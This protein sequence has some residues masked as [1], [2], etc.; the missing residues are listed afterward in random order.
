MKPRSHSP[1]DLGNAPSLS[2]KPRKRR[3]RR[4]TRKGDRRSGREPAL[5]VHKR[6]VICPPDRAGRH[7]LFRLGGL[8]CR[9]LVI[10]L[11]A[12]GFVTFLSDALQFGVPGSVIFLSTLVTVIL[13]M[14]FCLH[15]IGKVISPLLAGGGVT[16][17]VLLRPDLPTNLLYGV[18]SLYNAALDRLYRIGYLTYVQYKASIPASA[19]EEELRLLGVALLSVLVALLFTACFAKRVRLIPPAIL[20]TTILVVTLTFNIYSNRIESNLG[21]ALIIIS[22]ASVLVMATYDRL[23]NGRDNGLYD[24][25]LQLFSE[26]DRPMMPAEYAEHVA[27][28]KARRAARRALRR[29]QRERVVTVDEELTDYFRAGKKV[30]SPSKKSRADR[31]SKRVERNEARALHRRVRAA[32]AYDRATGQ[33]KTAM[34]GYAAA[35]VLVICLIAVA[36]PAAAIK[37]NF[38]TIA[39][40]DEK[41][42]LA[43]SYVT[44]LLRGDNDALDRLEY[45]ADKDNFKPRDTKLEQPEFQNKQVLYVQ[46][47]YNANYYLRGW[48]GTDYKD[49][50]WQAVDEATLEEYQALFGEDA[51]PAEDMR[52]GFYHYMMPTLVRRPD[53]MPDLLDRYQANLDYGFVGV[54]V[55]MRRVN[56]PSSMTYFPASYDR[57]YGVF[58]FQT[59]T[60]SALT[61]V[62]YYDGLYTGR[63][64]DENALSY[65]TMAYAPVM[66]RPT[67]IQNQARLQA[68][69]NLQKEALLPY[70]AMTVKE[71][72]TVI[73]Q[74]ELEVF[75]IGD[76][77]AFCYTIKKR[78]EEDIT[79]TMYHNLED[80]FHDTTS[81][82]ATGRRHRYIINTEVGSLTILMDG[83][84]VIGTQAGDPTEGINLWA[85]YQQNLSDD[86]R[87]ELLDYLVTE[88][89]YSDFV[90]RTYLGKAESTYL[91][92]LATTI[93]EQAHTEE[94]QVVEETLPD[95]P[96]TPEDESGTTTKLAW[97]NVPTDVSLAAMRNAS[98]EDV[99]IQRDRLVRNVIDYIITEMGCTYTL[100]PDLTH[101]D[102]NL[103][104]V[105]N[106]LR[107]TK[108]GYCVQFASAVTLLLRE[109]GIPARYVEGYIANDFKRISNE[110]FVYYDYVMDYEAH[111][112]V[113]V[114]FDGVGW[115]QYEAT[116]AYYSGLYG[117]A[118]SV[119]T[120]P[121][122]PV[123]PETETESESLLSPDE[124]DTEPGTTD[125]TGEVGSGEEATTG[126]NASSVI[127]TRDG[128]I[129]LGVVTGIAILAL[130]VRLI[131]SRARTAEDHRESL[132]LQVLDPVF[133][134]HT[135]EEDRREMAL[136]MGDAVTTLL[137]YYGLSPQP[138]EFRDDYADRLTAELTTPREG[139]KP[140]DTDDLPDLHIV[141][142][143][144]AAEEFGHGMSVAEMKAL[145]AFYLFL[146]RDVRRRIP[147]GERLR[148]RYIKRKI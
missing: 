89:T 66:T 101:V 133:G 144:M 147:L 77:Y 141:L 134:T 3:N 85:R 139:K 1:A 60:P 100:T 71:D 120:I 39:A 93:K 81:I 88:R 97:V 75:A 53:Y 148:L 21:I 145:A 136:E 59:V 50:A 114:Y 92:D 45:Q 10:W 26:D 140:L 33:A 35:A 135:S 25:D 56:S 46:S 19:S 91:Q 122:D 74:V 90:Y 23:Y 99:Y 116:P 24:H 55:H 117:T 137:G 15:P 118:S 124:S 17:M 52:Y 42:A 121:T 13:T 70:T 37:G 78:G 104:G 108:E 146:H 43:R 14:G 29:G 57:H 113:E 67:W 34:G 86:A 20:V 27:T 96:K 38:S 82:L 109:L 127:I 48:L 61:Y 105:E 5:S 72:G 110:D 8:I 32:K 79:W 68:A 142:G 16:A 102:P 87:R 83:Q 22:F 9:G 130:L 64:F 143:G 115:I 84:S 103:D 44:A 95:D 132:M 2:S 94:W 106:F 18:L 125:T 62:N 111:A 107:N 30:K 98:D 73:S 112:W 4:A 28:R 54:L 128:L 119:G 58:D 51:S 63:K 129:G 49:G 7:P 12:V 138:G 65:T 6:P 36:L 76:T 40:I 69:Y 41:V 11:A 126:T 31:A 131:V 80:V 47:R 123:L